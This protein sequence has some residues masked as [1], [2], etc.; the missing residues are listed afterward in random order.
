LRIAKDFS[1]RYS[2]TFTFFMPTIM[3]ADAGRTDGEAADI[4]VR[5]NERAVM[6]LGGFNKLH[7]AKQKPAT[8]SAILRNMSREMFIACF[9]MQACGH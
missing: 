7:P 1:D 5:T 8:Q 3:F 4:G 9:P 6:P 2:G